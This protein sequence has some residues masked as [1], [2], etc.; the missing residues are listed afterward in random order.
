MYSRLND[1]GLKG[2]G[3]HQVATVL[4]TSYER[5]PQVSIRETDRLED[6]CLVCAQKFEL[7]GFFTQCKYFLMLLYFLATSFSRDFNLMVKEL[8]KKL[9]IIPTGRKITYSRNSNLQRH[10]LKN[11][12]ENKYLHS[13]QLYFTFSS[14]SSFFKLCISQH[15]TILVLDAVRA[16]E[17]FS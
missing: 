2:D 16:K 7:R 8:L 10:N 4:L 5:S 17:E 12:L 1:Q 6:F 14:F 13:I 9:Y 15:M 3:D 11:A